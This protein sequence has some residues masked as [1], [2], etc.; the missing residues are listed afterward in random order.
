MAAVGG[1]G[2]PPAALTFDD[3]KSYNELKRGDPLQLPLKA[4]INIIESSD[5][6]KLFGNT[7]PPEEFIMGLKAAAAEDHGLTSDHFVYD[8]TT[9]LIKT[10]EGKM[11]NL[12]TCILPERST[13]HRFDKEGESQEHSKEVPIFLGNKTSFAFYT[14]KKDPANINALRSSYTTTR[15]ARL[16]DMNTESLKKIQFLDITKE[17]R[18]FFNRFFREIET[19]DGIISFIIPAQFYGSEE[20]KVAKLEQK[21]RGEKGVFFKTWNRHFAEI[22][23]RLGFDGWVVKPWN[24][25]GQGIQEYSVLFNI[26][27]PMPPEIV[28]CRWADVMEKIKGGARRRQTRRGKRSR[29]LTRSRS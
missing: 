19:E 28:I 3:P 10:A 26:L 22:I 29:A 12:P 5:I 4:N 11:I 9:K 17:E 1:A 14:G 16:F 13:L 23:C 7:E 15:P 24:E 6:T 21:K 27:K 8:A 20:E 25:E 18:N 2:A